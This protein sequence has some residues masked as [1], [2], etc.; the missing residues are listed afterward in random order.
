MRPRPIE[1]LSPSALRSLV[2]LLLARQTLMVTSPAPYTELQRAGYAY[3]VTSVR[4][5]FVFNED[6]RDAIMR[7]LRLT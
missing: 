7:Q 6:N 5:G 4:N 3:R 1:N 2:K